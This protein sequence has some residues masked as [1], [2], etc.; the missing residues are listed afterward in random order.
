MLENR[1]KQYFH[2]HARVPAWRF[3]YTFHDRTRRPSGTSCRKC[4][5][6]ISRLYDSDDPNRMMFLRLRSKGL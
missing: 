4:A 1:V 5:L 6:A 3:G 2:D